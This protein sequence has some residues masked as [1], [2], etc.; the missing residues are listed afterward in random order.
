MKETQ[1]WE[2]YLLNHGPIP[3][4]NKKY[5]RMIHV[6]GTNKADKEE[7]I[8]LL[9]SSFNALETIITSE[10]TAL[11]LLDS[12]PEAFE[13]TLTD[14]LELIHF[15]LHIEL[16]LLIGNIHFL[17][18]SLKEA[19]YSEHQLLKYLDTQ[20]MYTTDIYIQSV[21]S[22]SLELEKLY[23]KAYE[24]IAQDTETQD[25]IL[26]L[27]KNDGNVMQSASELYIHR[28][29]IIY[30]MNKFLKTTHLDLKKSN[31]R[32]ISYLLTMRLLCKQ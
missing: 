14:I 20:I 6:K 19:Y 21:L 18:E 27:W 28:N 7:L 15:D 5:I 16:Q 10:S 2:D 30:R 8:F 32:L 24:I 4:S 29:T 31:D 11:V 12:F 1:T 22:E 9:N 17:N 3:A 13:D 26:A 25:M 23:P